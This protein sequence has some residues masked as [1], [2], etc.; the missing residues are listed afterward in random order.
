MA[1][2]AAPVEEKP[3]GRPSF[4]VSTL[5]TTVADLL[6]DTG[7][8]AA[9]A[10]D[11][12]GDADLKAWFDNGKAIVATVQGAA[13][14]IKR[15][16][17]DLGSRL[18]QIKQTGSALAQAWQTEA[19]S[20]WPNP[21]TI[22]AAASKARRLGNLAVR[23][24]ILSQDQE[25]QFLGAVAS[26]L[27]LIRADETAV[28]QAI[29]NVENAIGKVVAP[30]LDPVIGLHD[31]AV[32]IL[33]SIQ[34]GLSDIPNLALFLQVQTS[35]ITDLFD[36]APIAADAA[37]LKAAQALLTG[38]GTA[39]GGLAILKQLRN[40]WNSKGGPALVLTGRKVEAA[41]NKLLHG[42]LSDF[43]SVSAI[44]QQIEDALIDLIPARYDLNY[45]FNTHVGDLGELF[46]IDRD[47]TDENDDDE[48][49][50]LVISANLW[51]NLLKP[52]EHGVSIKGV[53]QPFKVKLLPVLDAV[54]LSF[55]PVTFTSNDGE[56][57]KLDVKVSGVEIGPAMEFLKPLAEF[58]SPGGKNGF[59]IQPTISPPGLEAGFG[60]DLGTISIGTV[61]FINVS[62]NASVE[63]PF[64]DSPA[65][66]VVSLSRRT[67]PFIISAAPYGGGGFFALI[68]TTKGIVGFEAAFEFG[69]A[70]AF[71]YGP[72][73]AEGRITLGV[74]VSKN[75]LS[76]QIGGYF[77]AGGSARIACFAVSA[78][79]LVTIIQTIGGSM[80][81]EATFTFSFS[82]GLCDFD[83]SVGVA[84]S[85]GN[86]FSSGAGGSQSSMLIEEDGP[87]IELAAHEFSAT[88]FSAQ[89]RRRMGKPAVRRDTKCM[90]RNW[91]EYRNYFDSDL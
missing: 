59:F 34:G 6:N 71:S 55:A 12:A 32:G 13:G 20:N 5:G 70:A 48:E 26:T 29:G 38:T 17:D 46:Q 42:Q 83:Y 57:A 8:I 31:Q 88:D 19:T 36:P 66:F 74:Y 60:L 78:S 27:T 82:C 73:D 67:A 51:V 84:H 40:D 43:I 80:D 91:P 81:G 85:M 4:I 47:N 18:V 45:D 69:G 72:L 56:K 52:S 35:T 10:N 65:H 49:H 25:R 30:I 2:K 54:T 24:G 15:F 44:Q 58:L 86:G 11:G 64:D 53:L 21:F 14:E 75:E 89:S 39:L 68:A 62:I 77:F 23:T 50:D 9:R 61:S 3:T 79:L 16:G 63:L 22:E 7:R 41:A 76:A 90:S 37:K 1:K 28:D 33:A 87:V